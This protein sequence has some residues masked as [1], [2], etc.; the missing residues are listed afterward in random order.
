MSVSGENI[1]DKN[2]KEQLEALQVLSDFQDKIIGNTKIL[3]DELKIEKKKDTDKLL[4][5]VTDALNWEMSILNS[6]LDFI[7]EKE[8]VLRKTDINH[9]VMALS[10]ALQTQKDDKIAEELEQSLLPMLLQVKAAVQE[11]R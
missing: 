9:A 4:K 7:N 5:S 2:K 1:M 11:V 3:I 6:T 8:E 10:E